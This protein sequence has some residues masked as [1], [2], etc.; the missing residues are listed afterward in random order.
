VTEPAQCPARL[1]ADNAGYTHEVYCTKSAGHAGPHRGDTVWHD[2]HTDRCV[3]CGAV[4]A[5]PTPAALLAA[6]VDHL[7]RLHPID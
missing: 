7:D 1:I 6:M 2:L 3:V 5:E 4:V